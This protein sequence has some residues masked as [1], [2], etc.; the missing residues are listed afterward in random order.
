M[1]FQDAL[2]F[3]Q[4]EQDGSPQGAEESPGGLEY[5]HRVQRLLGRRS[6]VGRGPTGGHWGQSRAGRGTVVDNKATSV[7]RVLRM[8]DFQSALGIM[9]PAAGAKATA[10]L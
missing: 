6:R 8:G 10:G 5:E 4:R 7:D 2:H 3:G 9:D 1:L